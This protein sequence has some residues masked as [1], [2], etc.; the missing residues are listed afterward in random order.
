MH[1]HETLVGFINNN[2]AYIICYLIILYNKQIL[3]NFSLCDSIFYYNNIII[4]MKFIIIIIIIM[5]IIRIGLCE[6][7]HVSSCRIIL[8]IG[9]LINRTTA[10]GR[11]FFNSRVLFQ[12]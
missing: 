7:I 12:K 5:I 10:S 1:E 11:I 4:P 2:G 8:Q 9:L 3:D 6:I